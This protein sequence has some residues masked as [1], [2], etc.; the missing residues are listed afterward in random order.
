MKEAEFT[1]P[2]RR[3]FKS[4]DGLTAEAVSRYLEAQASA[5][6]RPLPPSKPWHSRGWA[7]YTG[8]P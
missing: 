3:E 2:F 1:F 7:N 8:E 4:L 6:R 5:K